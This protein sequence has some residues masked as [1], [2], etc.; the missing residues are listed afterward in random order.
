MLQKLFRRVE[1]DHH[2]FSFFDAPIPVIRIQ[3]FAPRASGSRK[4]RSGNKVAEEQA[5]G[6]GKQSKNASVAIRRVRSNFIRGS[7]ENFALSLPCQRMRPRT[8]PERGLRSPQYQPR[9]PQ[10]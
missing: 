7:A 10:P 9:S 3:T 1:R 8:D 6:P 4:G 5:A 2:S